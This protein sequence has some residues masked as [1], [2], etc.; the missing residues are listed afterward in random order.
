M[1]RASSRLSE[2]SGVALPVLALHGTADMRRCIRIRAVNHGKRRNSSDSRA[3]GSMLLRLLV[4]RHVP[5]KT[6]RDKYMDTS[7]IRFDQRVTGWDGM[8]DA[9]GE[10]T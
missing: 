3:G 2:G 9:R 8:S 1:L 5:R 7:K 4:E 10:S 6:L